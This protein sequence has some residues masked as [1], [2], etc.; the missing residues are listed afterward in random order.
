MHMPTV[1]KIAQYYWS[2]VTNGYGKDFNSLDLDSPDAVMLNHLLNNCY[3]FS[4]AKNKT[5]LQQLTALINNNGRVREWA[6]YYSEAQKLNLKL[7]K[8]WLKT[9][10]DLAI[11]G[12]TMAS[13][14]VQFES[15]PNAL[16]RYSTVG[17]ARVRAEHKAMD[18]ITLPANHP[19]WNTA[20]PPN[21]FKCRCDV[22][23]LPYSATATPVDKI[24]PTG[25]DLVFP[26]NH[27]YYLNGDVTNAIIKAVKDSADDYEWC[28][29]Y[30]N[31]KTKGFVHSHILTK[32]Q[33]LSDGPINFTI[34]K[35]LADMGDSVFILPV[36]NPK[37]TE[38]IARL[39]NGAKKGKF[40]DIKLNGNFV[41]IEGSYSFESSAY[42]A[43]KNTIGRALKQAD[44]V[45]VHLHYSVDD[46][47]I[48]NAR[49]AIYKYNNS[50]G[51]KV[52]IVIRKTD[53]KYI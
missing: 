26:K 52:K 37:E 29:D 5:H 22:D 4:A 53:G 13:K 30:Y 38:L 18:G 42:N 36:L 16:L 19:F 8:T 45:I 23:R 35:E 39:F 32:T 49:N 3:T 15:T 10:Y 27:P 47:V 43:I 48:N 7:N 11:A 34:A 21:G 50:K 6:A 20:Y 40:P 9:E 46:A 14:W 33:N 17:D 24:P 25:T 2:A 28:E 12:A 44:S 31:A 51:K 41:E 1:H